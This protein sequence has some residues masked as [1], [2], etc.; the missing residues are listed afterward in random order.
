[1]NL[2]FSYCIVPYIDRGCLSG[3]PPWDLQ[4]GNSIS[5]PALKIHHC[6]VMPKAARNTNTINSHQI[7]TSIHPILSPLCQLV[8]L[9]SI[10]CNYGIKA[11]FLLLLFVLVCWFGLP[12]RQLL[13]K[14][15]KTHRSS[16]GQLKYITARSLFRDNKVRKMHYV[17]PTDTQSFLS[18][19][20]AC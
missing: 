13:I 16:S 10:E 5:P 8:V 14:N 6:L 19:R 7:W 2:I 17:Y 4:S 1:M 11:G 12:G 20:Q 15:R 9:S 3:L 18:R